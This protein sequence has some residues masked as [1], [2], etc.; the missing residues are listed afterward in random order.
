MDICGAIILPTIDIE[1]VSHIAG[2]IDDVKLVL[3]DWICVSLQNSYVDMQ[4]PMW[5]C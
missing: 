3:M 5:W 4:L 1:H 2:R